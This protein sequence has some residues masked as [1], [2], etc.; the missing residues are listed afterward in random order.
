MKC[1]QFV[2]AM[3]HFLCI[4]CGNQNAQKFNLWIVAMA[5]GDAITASQKK[6]YSPVT[7]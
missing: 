1:N 7:T 6:K 2:T 5:T 4:L 3:E